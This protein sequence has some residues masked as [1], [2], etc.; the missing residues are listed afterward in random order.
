MYHHRTAVLIVGGG[1]AGLSSA[2]F[3]ARQDVPVLLV[4]RHSGTLIHPRARTINSRTLE[5]YRQAGLEEEILAARRPFDGKIIL[6]AG[7]LS[8]PEE[9]SRPMEMQEDARDASPCPWVPID[10]DVLETILRRRAEE[11]GADIRFSTRLDGFDLDRGGVTGTLRDLRSGR[12]DV[13]RADYLIAADGGP[14]PIRERLCVPRAGAGRLGHTV[15]LVFEADLSEA[16]R[17]RSVG[18]CHLREPILGTV[19]MPHDSEE[20]W[21][22]SFPYDPA[23][24]E[25]PE[26]FTEDLSVDLIRKAVGL[27]DLDVR[28]VPQLADGTTVLAYDIDALLAGTYR[29][30]RAFL[31][32]DSAHSMPPSG[33][34][35][36]GT[37]I[38]DAHNLAWKLA[39]VLHGHAGPALL[40][41]YEA[42]RRPVAAK[43]IAQAVLK[44][45]VNMGL[46]D[47]DAAE[48]LWPSESVILGYTYGSGAVIGGEPTRFV[49][50]AELDGRPGGRAPH[51]PARLAGRDMSLLDLYGR[52][53]VLL[54]G[55]ATSAWVD[56]VPKV[57]G[58]FGL[59][60]DAYRIGIDIEVPGGHEAHGI[61]RDGAVLVRP[62]GFVGW[63][64]RHRPADPVAALDQ[65][66][67]RLLCRN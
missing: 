43:T 12:D 32:G 39:A 55:G 51:L 28:I 11:L 8:G 38:Q 50:P 56:A 48:T 24:G 34:Y 47:A 40:S 59:P 37:G 30:G 44:R 61:A 17:G 19:L 23:R 1:L 26:T 4:E 67:T 45:E 27:P 14:S 54:S 36:S 25:S 6:H 10:Q 66:V 60:V 7:T 33:A 41:S 53:L 35:G 5:L 2:V 16:L 57:T 42:E 29:V 15:T 64:A 31:V 21:V 52:G 62:D 63:R 3:L 58:G 13:V 18:L 49:P 20:R 9:R 65:A 22:V 46:A